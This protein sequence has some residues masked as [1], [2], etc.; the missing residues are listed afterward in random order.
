LVGGKR[1]EL[2]SPALVAFF[3][4]FVEH[5]GSGKSCSRVR[6]FDGAVGLAVTVEVQQIV[7]DMNAQKL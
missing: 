3:W 5:F 2:G 1:R 6:V 7:M 4:A